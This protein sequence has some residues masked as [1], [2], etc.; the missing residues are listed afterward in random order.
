MNLM[1]SRIISESEFKRKIEEKKNVN[2]YNKNDNG[3]IFV[4]FERSNS[5][6]IK[7][8]SYFM[9]NDF[10]GDDF[11]CVVVV[12][13]DRNFGKNKIEKIYS[14]PDI[15]DELNKIFIDDLNGNK[16]I[17]L[18]YLL[19]GNLK[20]IKDNLKDKLNLDEK[21]DIILENYLKVEL[22]E[23]RKDFEEDNIKEYIEEIKNY[24]KEEPL[25]KDKI[26][27]L[28]YKLIDDFEYKN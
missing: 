25:I 2:E 13:I 9:S 4:H 16:E 24:M 12:H 15:N 6:N 22:E 7:F 20:E 8:V 1:I 23:K 26:I 19:S 11:N 28:A 18:K 17:K 14:L 5:K 10:K 27:V 21:F 3:N